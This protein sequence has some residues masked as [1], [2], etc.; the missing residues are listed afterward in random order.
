LRVWGRLALIAFGAVILQVGVLNQVVIGGVHL[1]LFLLLA[2]CAGFVAGPQR[3][4]VM[5]FV[6]GLLA[7]IF[8][9]TP[10]GLSA[11]CF[12]L[13]AFAVG[14]VVEALPGL[15]TFGFQL[16]T[17]LLGGILGTLLF[18]GLAVVMGQPSVSH[19]QLA[20]IAIVVGAGCVL[21][22]RPVCM[23]MEW[24]VAVAPGIRRDAEI[25]AG[26]SAR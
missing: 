26:G 20:V 2:I 22:A 15:P 23:L 7:D 4:A 19:G 10:F 17:A 25:F 18:D 11:L 5:G 16:V 21:L 3:G 1:D 12:V 13:V 9:Q 8:V 14:L 24:T 6:L